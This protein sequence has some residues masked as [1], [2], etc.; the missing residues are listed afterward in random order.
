MCMST[1]NQ[2]ADLAIGVTLGA[3]TGGAG[4][5]TLATSLGTGVVSAATAGAG[6]TGF[7]AG[8]A[9]AIGGGILGGVGSFALS[10]FG[11]QQQQ[12]EYEQAKIPEPELD[13]TGSGGRNAPEVFAEAVKATKLA[14]R[15]SDPATK[16]IG[17]VQTGL[18][19]GVS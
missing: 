8:V 12:Q 4:F 11:Q 3:V 19:L 6:F 16:N 14:E 10:S 13:I 2:F 5:S 7:T 18:Q 15:T 1:G 9:G 17:P